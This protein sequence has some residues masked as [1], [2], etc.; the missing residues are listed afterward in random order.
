[1]PLLIH[2]SNAKIL[3]FHETKYSI[4]DHGRTYL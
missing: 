3:W 1:V 4:T 2:S